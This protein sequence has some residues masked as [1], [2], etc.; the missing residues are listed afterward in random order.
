MSQPVNHPAGIY[1]AEQRPDAGE[2]VLFLHG[3]S[4]AGWS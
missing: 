4:A 2:S 3:G 1:L